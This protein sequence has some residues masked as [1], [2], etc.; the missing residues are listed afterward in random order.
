MKKTNKR[1]RFF[2]FLW[3]SGETP[4]VNWDALLNK[5]IDKGN[6]THL[7]DYYV[8]FDDKYDVWITNHPYSSGRLYAN[9][10]GIKSQP[11]CSKKTKIRLEDFV[12][13]L[14]SPNDDLMKSTINEICNTKDSN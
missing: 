10:V 1:E 6:V 8:T 7:N 11:H 9:K 3:L 14:S 5:L 12:N 4:N 13:K 2:K